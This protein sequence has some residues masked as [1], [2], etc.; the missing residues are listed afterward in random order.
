[1]KTID[2]ATESASVDDILNR[3]IGNN[4]VVRTAA[5]KEFVIT[6]LDQPGDDDDF[7]LEVALARHNKA[8]RSLLSE[9]SKEPGKY[10][11]D[12]VRQKLGLAVRME[13]PS[14]D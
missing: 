9:R 1:M 7:A 10:S 13:R 3:A 4:L 11:I 14:P 12:E 2:L 6:E 8:L 5:G